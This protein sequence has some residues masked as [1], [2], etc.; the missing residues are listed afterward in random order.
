MTSV[1]RKVETETQVFFGPDLIELVLL[2][3]PHH[4]WVF[5][6]YFLL[7]M[8]K[9]TYTMSSVEREMLAYHE[10]GHAV[11]GWMLEH[12]DPLLKVR[13]ECVCFW[14]W[15]RGGGGIELSLYQFPVV[16]T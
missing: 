1:Y 12:V 4:A 11:V 9:K 6:K 14:G 5:M 3:A 10:A 2:N 16:H 15:V 7:G 8:E 13:E